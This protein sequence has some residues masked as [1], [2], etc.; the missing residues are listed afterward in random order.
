MKKKLMVLGSLGEFVQLIQMGK[1]RGIEMIVCDRYPDGPGKK[2]ADKS[3]DIDA[4]DTK[5]AAK[6]CKQE[7]VDGIITSFS[8]YL[9]E[10]MVKISNEARLKC[11]IKPEQLEYYRNKSVMKEMFQKLGI[12]TPKHVS[13]KKNFEN[14][15]LDGIQF[16]VVIKP[17]D[18]YGSR[19][20]IV[21]RSTD[22]IRRHFEECCTTSEIKE[23]IAEEYNE[24]Y[25]FNMM[26]W[27]YHGEVKV[28]SIADREKSP[29]GGN[30]I[31]ISSRNVYPSRYIHEVYEEAK[32]ILQKIAD[33]TGQRDGALSMQF[34]WS[35]GRKIQVCEAA[36][37]FFGYEHELVEYS[38]GL[39]LEDILLDYIYDEERLGRLLA[40][41]NPF[42]DTH[43]AVLYFHGREKKIAD[44]SSARELSK[45]D[46]VKESWLF[47]EDGEQVVKFGPKPYAVRYYITG[48][49]REELDFLT[50][51]IYNKITIIDE[52]G[53]EVLYPNRMTDYKAIVSSEK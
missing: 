40:E 20:V 38:S 34:F 22:E 47:Y 15:E 45:M 39:K 28:I 37:R 16:P 7:E 11:Y 53:K 32:E 33:F 35:E 13:L 42:M 19:G 48:K 1:E 17:V 50:E 44:Q 30:E 8:D 9:F 4:G 52:S 6:L 26:T 24:G 29:I 43:S 25:E 5:K 46:G 41:H 23:I 12:G 10:C 31:P 18:R 49:S 51:E 36:G 3:Y 14:R 27:V 21:V 2:E